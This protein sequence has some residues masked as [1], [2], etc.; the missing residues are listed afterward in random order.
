MRIKE[1][2]KRKKKEIPI[3][4]CFML[5]YIITN[6]EVAL[7]CAEIVISYNCFFKIICIR[8][9]IEKIDIGLKY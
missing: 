1:I 8:F 3:L 7:L 5:L 2:W 6:K 4:T 9:Y